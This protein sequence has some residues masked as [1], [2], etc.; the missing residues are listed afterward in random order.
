MRVGLYVSDMGNTLPETDIAPEKM[1]FLKRKI[2]F[3]PYFSGTMLVW[4][5]V[6]SVYE[7]SYFWWK[8]A[9]MGDGY[10]RRHVTR[11]FFQK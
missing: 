10:P 8:Y 6:D 2:M 7:I 3:N 4:D 1:L 9:W 5:S 11:Y